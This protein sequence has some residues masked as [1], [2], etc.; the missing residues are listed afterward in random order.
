MR[1]KSQ[2]S[3]IAAAYDGGPG[4]ISMPWLCLFTFLTGVGGCA[5]FAGAVKTCKALY[6]SAVARS[7]P[8]Q[9]L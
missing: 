1:P 5:S 2:V 4:S 9:P 8:F 7:S 6:A 3:N